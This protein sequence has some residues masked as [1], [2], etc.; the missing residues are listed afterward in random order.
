MVITVNMRITLGLALLL[1]LGLLAN[2]GRPGSE[3]D[4]DDDDDN[5]GTPQT[6]GQN[7]ATVLTPTIFTAGH[8]SPYWSAA[9]LAGVAWVMYGA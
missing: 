6:P 4:D 2:A 9:A 8:D 3:D 5:G 7:A 1:T